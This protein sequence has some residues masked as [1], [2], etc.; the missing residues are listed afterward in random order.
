MVTTAPHSNYTATA[1]DYIHCAID[2]GYQ[3]IGVFFYQD[4]V[5][6]ASQHLTVPND[7]FQAISSWRQLHKAHN[8]PLY[9]CIS[10]AQKRGLSDELEQ[11]EATSN[12]DE[13]FTISGLGE[14]VSLTDEADKV[15]Q[16]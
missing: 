6:N 16:L 5:L 11:G 1:L 8:I 4:G 2:A 15:V 13:T 7:E 9:L 14:L 3:V 12:I 10:A